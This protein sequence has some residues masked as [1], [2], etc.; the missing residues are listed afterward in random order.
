MCFLQNYVEVYDLNKDPYQLENI[1]KQLDP[2]V[3]LEL[4]QRLMKLSICSGAS[5]RVVH[6]YS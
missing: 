1:V 4:N 2:K 6:P 5:C 3:H